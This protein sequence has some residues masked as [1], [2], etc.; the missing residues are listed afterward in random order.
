M[1]GFANAFVRYFSAFD[2]SAEVC[3]RAVTIEDNRFPL[4]GR[5]EQSRAIVSIAWVSNR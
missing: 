5:F 1:V 2:F 3:S 4:G